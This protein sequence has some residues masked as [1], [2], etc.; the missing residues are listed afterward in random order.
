MTTIIGGDEQDYRRLFQSYQS[1]T[2]IDH[3]YA[4]S[5]ERNLPV[6]FCRG[7]KVPLRELWPRTRHLI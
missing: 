6:Y 3:P 5:F 1:V 4:R 2:V 7:L